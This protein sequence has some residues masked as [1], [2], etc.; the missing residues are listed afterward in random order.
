M[1]EQIVKPTL[2]DVN[3]VLQMNPVAQLQLQ[4]VAVSRELQAAHERIEELEKELLK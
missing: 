3:K 1:A 2:D 4:L